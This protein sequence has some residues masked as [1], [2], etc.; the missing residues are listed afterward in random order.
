VSERKQFRVLYRAFLSRLIDFEVLSARGQVQTLLAQFAAMLAALSFT[1]IIVRIPSFGKARLSPLNLAIA[2]WGDEHFLIAL[3]LTITGLFA[4]LSWSNMFPDR[5]DALILGSLPVRTAVV[6]KAK[7]W[8]IGAVLG[9]SVFALNVFT[10]LAY[11]FVLRAPTGFV[12][13]SFFAYWVTMAAVTI[14]VFSA[15]LALQGLAAQIFSYRFFLRVSSFVQLTAF[16]LIL[17]TFFLSPPVGRLTPWMPSIWFL[18]FFQVL[19]GSTSDAFGPLAMRAVLALGSSLVIAAITFGLAF[20]RS[21]RRMVEQPD[22]TPAD[23][24]RPASRVG[25]WLAA[26]LLRQPIERAILLFTARTMARSRQ[27]RMLLAV[28]GG[29]GLAIGLAYARSVVYGEVPWDQPSVQLLVGSF[30]LLFFSA[31]GTRAVFALPMALRANWIFRIT[32]VHSPTTYFKAVHKAMLLLACGPVWIASAI[33]YLAV[34][35]I[36]PVIQHMAI[37]MATGAMLVYLLMFRFRK[38][39]F[40]CSYQPGKTDL[41]IKLGSRAIIFLFLANLGTF[42]EFSAM[43]RPKLY[44]FVLAALVGLAFWARRRTVEFA[45]SRYLPVQFEELPPDE[46]TVLDLKG[47]G[48]LTGSERYVDA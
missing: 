11:P 12:L 17:S 43:Q 4:V 40:A 32:S 38:L 28:Y 8:A 2:A 21:V 10:G 36:A 14:F 19:N 46:I 30:V 5:S 41:R 20:N 18:G 34:W 1:I 44:A 22:I 29:I 42:L 13:R 9:T 48:G 27:H 47:D 26:R 39:P 16:F 31:I 7:L 37:M 15:S 24:T 3:T 23:R 45:Q 33:F 25:G 35:R 6:L